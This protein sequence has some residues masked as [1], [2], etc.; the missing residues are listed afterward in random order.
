MSPNRDAESCI[1]GRWDSGG[2]DGGIELKLQAK[3]ILNTWMKNYVTG[4]VIDA[5]ELRH[6]KTKHKR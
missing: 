5:T 4:M 3:I 6:K 1:S 2:A